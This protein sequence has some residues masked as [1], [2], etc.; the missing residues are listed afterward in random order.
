VTITIDQLVRAA[1]GLTALAQGIAIPKDIDPP[2]TPGELAVISFLVRNPAPSSIGD[3]ARV[4]RLAQSRVSSVVR[5]LVERGWVVATTPIHDRRATLVQ[6]RQEVVEGARR[7][8]SA[9]V[10]TRLAGQLDASAGEL[11]AIVRGIETLNAVLDRQIQ[12]EPE[13]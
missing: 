2:L 10:G 12:K 9:D 8:L 6:A 5:N 1:K 3:L 7:V 13:P 4:T 11:K